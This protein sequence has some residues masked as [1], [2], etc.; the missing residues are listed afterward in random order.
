LL[1]LF[2]LVIS[3]GQVLA[4]PSVPLRM[5]SLLQRLVGRWEMSG[6]V[7]GNAVAYRLDVER[8]LQG[9]FIQLHM[10]DVSRP[11]RYEA[12][13]FLGVDSAQSRYI[14]HWMDAFGAGFSIPPGIGA[15][16]GDTVQL[17]FDYPGGPFRDHFVYDR[18]QDSWYFRLES[19][20]TSRVWRLFA[21]YQV[22]RR[23]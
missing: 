16:R 10:E 20:D 19:Q 17:R 12:S 23:R 6:T 8:V 4:Q 1:I 18:R 13:V 21:E 11:P 5:D 3:Q 22:R 15:M 2:G 14:A 7:R 9:R